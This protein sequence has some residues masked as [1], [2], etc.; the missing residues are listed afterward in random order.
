MNITVF[1]SVQEVGEAYTAAAREFATLIARSGHTLVW[2]G[3]NHGTMRVIAD[4]A[5][6]AGGRIVG[7]SVEPIKARARRN[8]DEMIIAKDWPERRATLLAR[9]DA[10]AVLPGGLGTLDELTEVLEYKKQ[11]AH[12]KPVVIL[13][14]N[15]FYDG[16]R[17]QFE[18]MDDEGFFPRQLSHY[19]FFATSAEEA[20]A[21]L[22]AAIAGRLP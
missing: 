10:V 12:D 13:N 16:L 14:V 19:L 3:S 11:N 21:Y 22:S 7:V 4:A 17:L 5:Q 15:G 6:T 20:M 1:C 18:R 9:G 2:G 8:A